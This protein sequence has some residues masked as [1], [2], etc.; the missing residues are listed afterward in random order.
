MS[1]SLNSEVSVGRAY[2][3]SAQAPKSSILHLSEQK[4]RNSLPVNSTSFPQFGH[5]TKGIV[6]FPE[7]KISIPADHAEIAARNKKIVTKQQLSL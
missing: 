6:L 7:T 3:S 4:G 5:L 1:S 2:S